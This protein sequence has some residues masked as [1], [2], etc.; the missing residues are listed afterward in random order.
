MSKRT[1]P[2]DTFLKYKHTKNGIYIIVKKEDAEKTGLQTEICSI[3][4]G[5]TENLRV[6]IRNIRYRFN[7][8]IYI[9]NI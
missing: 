9:K 5:G 7:K 1:V 3:N 2:I 4:E 6:Y 8:R